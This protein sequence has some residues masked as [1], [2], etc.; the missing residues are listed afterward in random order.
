LG[1]Y[2]N[3]GLNSGAFCWS[4]TAAPSH[5]YAYIGGRLVYVPPVA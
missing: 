2:W 5:R 4:V 1:G 3:Y